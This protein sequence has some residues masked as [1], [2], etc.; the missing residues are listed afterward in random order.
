MIDVGR[1]KMGQQYKFEKLEVWQLAGEL[2]DLVYEIDKSLPK[3]EQFNLANQIRRASTSISLNIAEG[4]TTASNA[5]F[6]RFL[7]IAIRSYVEVYGCYLLMV[8]GPYISRGNSICTKIHESG[9]KLF[10]K[11]QALVKSLNG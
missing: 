6:T 3:S 8:R 1:K 10:A 2:F 5:E 9:A 7:K 11:L 4:S